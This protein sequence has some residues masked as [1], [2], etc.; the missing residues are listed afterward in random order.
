MERNPGYWRDIPVK[1]NQ[2]IR[3]MM[4]GFQAR[5]LIASNPT[6]FWWELP[7]QGT[8]VAPFTLNQVVALP[9]PVERANILFNPPPN[10]IQPDIVLQTPEELG[11]TARFR[12]V[13]LD[14]AP[15]SGVI[16]G[17][18]LQHS[19]SQLRVDLN[20]AVGAGNPLHTFVAPL[21][22]GFTFVLID[23]TPAAIQAVTQLR[24]FLEMP[25]AAVDVGFTAGNRQQIYYNRNYVIYNRIPSRT[26]VRVP[27]P[28]F[29][30]LYAV[31]TFADVSMIMEY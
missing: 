26:T 7:D 10:I 20:D 12:Y 22:S 5:A 6:P 23:R 30:R 2:N 24:L 25:D 15:Q 16:N 11:N 17:A 4:L 9:V 28:A 18:T 14:M 8:F 1:V 29:S 27:I 3:D 13:A 21:P 31:N 19:V